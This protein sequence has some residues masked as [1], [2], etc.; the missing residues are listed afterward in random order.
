MLMKIISNPEKSTWDELLIRPRIDHEV[1]EEQLQK[2]IND[3]ARNG[4]S[5]VKKYTKEF[6]H[7]DADSLEVSSAD[8][9]K[10]SQEVEPS[11]KK[12]I[13]EAHWNIQTFHK[14]QRSNFDTTVTTAGVR[15]WQKPVPISK[16]GLYIPGGSAP[17][18]STALM[19]GIPARIAGCREV[20]L[21]TPP[22]SQGKVSPSILYIAGLLGIDRVFRV[23]GAQAIAAMA[24]GT[25]SIPAV[26]KIFGPGNQYVATA[27]QIV[28]RNKVAI[29]LPAGPSELAVVADSTANPAFIASDL[30]S[31]AEHGPDS[32]VLLFSNSAEIIDQVQAELKK[33]LKDLPRKDIASKALEHSKMILLKDQDEIMA[34][35]NAYA[36]E[37]LILVTSNYA[38]LAEQVVNAGSVFLGDYTPESAGDY[39]SGTNHTLPTNGWAHVYSGVNMDSFCKK[40][41]FQEIS[42]YGL[43]NIGGAIMTMAEAEQLQAHSK[44]VSIRLNTPASD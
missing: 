16:V 2:I 31:Q 5:A 44:A 38:D 12:A 15:C 30:L 27:K 9:R 25:E 13:E 3:V 26:N 1:L 36:P 37:H 41:T 8:I 40:I 34:M 22:D 21:C 23:G 39:A 4:D 18:L 20:I 19:L 14:K 17:L 28:S 42:R 7:F 6:D 35:V 43:A 32:Q 29:D 24:Y 11:L 10:A 33:Q